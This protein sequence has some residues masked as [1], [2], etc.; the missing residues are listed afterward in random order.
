MSNAAV[1]PAVVE[2]YA[3]PAVGDA[4]GAAAEEF[5]RVGL[6]FTE[7]QKGSHEP[8]AADL[9]MLAPLKPLVEANFW[10]DIEENFTSNGGAPFPPTLA[11]DVVTFDKAADPADNGPH[12]ADDSGISFVFRNDDMIVKN[13]VWENGVTGVKID[14]IKARIMF[15]RPDGALVYLDRTLYLTMILAE[16]GTWDTF[17][18]RGP[19][20]R[21]GVA[22]TQEELDALP[23]V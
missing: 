15:T 10:G 9:E 6:S 21:E 5:I 11:G 4:I 13:H 16:D 20:D 12:K 17:E 1:D 19:V 3:D 18:Y 7:L 14:N 23:P 22:Q 2:A 8:S